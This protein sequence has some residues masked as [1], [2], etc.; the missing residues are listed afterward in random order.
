[1]FSAHFIGQGYDLPAPPTRDYAVKSLRQDGALYIHRPMKQGVNGPLALLLRMGFGAMLNFVNITLRLSFACRNPAQIRVQVVLNKSK[2][3]EMTDISG[4]QGRTVPVTQASDASSGP[5]LTETY[6]GFTVN[7]TVNVPIL[8]NLFQG[9]AMVVGAAFAAATLGLCVLPTALIQVD[10]ALMRMS[11]GIVFATLS[12]LLISY[13]NHGVASELQFDQGLGEVREVLRHRSGRTALIA[14]YGF[15][16]F[17]GISVDR[18]RGDPDKVDL[19]LRHQESSHN[20]IVATGSEAQIGVL[21]GRLERDLLRSG[22]K[23][24]FEAV[25][26]L[27]L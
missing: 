18:S 3:N 12:Y 1:M 9:A 8:V 23:R 6:W 17:T 14:H 15:D 7:S 11:V 10:S 5:L 21:F 2:G 19:V 16:A 27:P 4:F 25:T 22:G 24:K 20:L 13:A 26:P